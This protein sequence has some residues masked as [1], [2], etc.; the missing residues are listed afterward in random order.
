MKADEVQAK[1]FFKSGEQLLIPIWQRHYAWEKPQ[2]TELWTDIERIRDTEEAPSHFIGSIVVK[3]IDYDGRRTEA[4]RYYVV[5]GQQRI[6]TLTILVCAIR[7]RLAQLESTVEERAALIQNF[8]SQELLNANL[9]EG[10]RERLVLQK[11]D[12]EALLPLIQGVPNPGSDT[13][14]DRAYAFFKGKL[15]PM[16]N[17]ALEELLSLIKTHLTAVWVGLDNNDNAHRVFQ[18]LNAGGKKLRQADLVRNYFFLLLAESGEE[19]FTS[20]WLPMEQRLSDDELVDYMVAWSVSQGHNGSKESLFTYFHR[21][22]VPFERSL[23]DVLA[24]GSEFTGTSRIFRWIREPESSDLSPN[25]KSVATDLRNWSTLPADGLLLW[26]LRQRESDRMTDDQ[27]AEAFEIVLSFMARRQLAGY[28]PNLHKSIF[29]QT[30][31]TLRSKPNHNGQ[32]IVEHLHYALSSGSARSTWPSDAALQE[33]A[34]TTPIYTRSRHRWVLG[35]L[36]RINRGMFV[37]QKHQP[38]VLDRSTLTIEHVMPQTLSPAWLN[39]LSTWGVQEPIEKHQ[40]LVHVLGNLTLTPINSE[41]SNAQFSRKKELFEDDWLRLNARI[42]DASTWSPARID[43][44]SGELARIACS[45]FKA[46]MTQ[47]EQAAAAPRFSSTPRTAQERAEDEEDS[48]P[49]EEDED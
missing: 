6:T 14:V 23:N 26:L 9:K 8:N 40:E 17:E 21:D 18:T 10:H 11:R 24:Y 45:V 4:Q 32:E 29:V 19:F 42:C 20:S 39:D 31:R 27:L 47:D 38:P 16:D 13:L 49:F 33:A 2:L 41:L 28:E 36:E 43:E 30:T 48:D 46:P 25:A 37:M 35:L 12:R 5:D 44:R 3:K 22:L 1:E 15:E 34:R 7:D